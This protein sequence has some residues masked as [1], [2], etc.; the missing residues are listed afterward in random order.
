MQTAA[1]PIVPI[2]RYREHGAGTPLS[3]DIRN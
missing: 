2:A 3:S 1:D